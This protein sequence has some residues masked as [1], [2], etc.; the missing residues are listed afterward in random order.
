MDAGSLQGRSVLVTGADG[1]IGSHLSRALIEQ[2]PRS[3][4]C[5]ATDRPWAAWSCRGSPA[6]S[7]RSPATSAMRA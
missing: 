7:T 4:S 2:G 1:L 6:A 3:S 5:A